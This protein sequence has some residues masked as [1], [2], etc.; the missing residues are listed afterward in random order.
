MTLNMGGSPGG[1]GVMQYSKIF[2][3]FFSDISPL[4]EQ[5]NRQVSHFPYKDITRVI[6]KGRDRLV[7]IGSNRLLSHL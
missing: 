2:N 6:S 1:G 5:S 3:T 7:E 4:I